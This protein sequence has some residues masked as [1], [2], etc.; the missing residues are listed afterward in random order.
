M[1]I[2]TGVMAS[3]MTLAIAQIGVNLLLGVSTIGKYVAIITLL[4]GGLLGMISLGLSYL[5][6]GL[7]RKVLMVLCGLILAALAVIYGQYHNGS[8]APLGIYALVICN[9]LIVIRITG[10]LARH[11]NEANLPGLRG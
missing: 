10:M 2:V 6:A 9:S 1:G 5:T 11:T 3:L 7:E 8:I 4:S